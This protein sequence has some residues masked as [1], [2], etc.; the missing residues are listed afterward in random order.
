M[1]PVPGGVV[2][3]DVEGAVEVLAYQQG[4]LGG[5]LHQG[6]VVDDSGFEFCRVTHAMF[7]HCLGHRT[8]TLS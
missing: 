4:V 7:S 1:V 8:S 5:V 2:D 6:E 3:V